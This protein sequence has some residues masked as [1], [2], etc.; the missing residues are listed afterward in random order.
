[1]DRK[2]SMSTPPPPLTRASDR[3]PALLLV[4]A[5][6]VSLISLPIAAAVGTAVHDSRSRVYAE[7]A[8]K[9]RTVTATVIGTG[10]S[11][12]NIE[13]PTITVPARWVISGT[14]HTG[15]VVAPRTVK[16]G[17]TV[18]VWL[19]DEGSPVGR[20]STTAVDEAVGSAFA[21]WLGATLSVAAL[22]LVAR[23]ALDRSRHA[24]WQRDIDDLLGKGVVGS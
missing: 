18:E 7:Q 3:L 6:A 17:D 23:M 14:E 19:D 9:Y 11:R 21:V 4:F 13:R 22:Y 2:D 5:V 20:P 1:V 16:V 12:R 10:N 24:A 15:D 8:G